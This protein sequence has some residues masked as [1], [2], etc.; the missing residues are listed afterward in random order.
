[1]SSQFSIRRALLCACAFVCAGLPSV[2][3]ADTFKYGDFTAA[4][5]VFQGVTEASATETSPVYGAPSVYGDAIAYNLSGVNVY[6]NRGTFDFLDAQFTTAIA[7]QSGYG[8]HNVNISEAGDYT[9]IGKG[10]SDT[11]VSAK[12]ILASL[13]VCAVDGATIT[14]VTTSLI[15]SVD[16]SLDT[17]S[18]SGLWNLDLNVDIDSLLAAKGYKG[19]AT[20]VTLTFDNSIYALSESTSVAYLAKKSLEVSAGTS[21]TSVPEPSTLALLGIG[22]IGLAFGAWRKRHSDVNTAA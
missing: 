20:L 5:V 11:A 19:K 13:K 15:A 3:R 21:G 4:S 1:V 9:L 14:P 16:Y 10:T 22:G 17:K 18:G 12:L 2:V 8:I 7:A 6:A